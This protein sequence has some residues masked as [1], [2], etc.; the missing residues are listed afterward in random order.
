MKNINL[1]RI[2]I[3][4]WRGKNIDLTFHEGV[5]KIS[6]KNEVGKTT[7]INAWNW[8]FTSYT[9]PTSLKNQELFDNKSELTH[10][11]PVAR[12]TLHISIDGVEHT[13]ERTAQAKFTRPQGSLEYVKSSTDTYTTSIDGF[14]ISAR[15]FMSWIEENIC[16]YELI[17]FLLDGAFF[18]TMAENDRAKARKALDGV[19]GEICNE[20]YMGDYSMITSL[21]GRCTVEQLVANSSAELRK[22]RADLANT[23]SIL[24]ESKKRRRD[25][26]DVDPEAINAELDNVN[27][28][29]VRIQNELSDRGEDKYRLHLLRAKR[30]QVT[31]EYSKLE[32]EY[33]LKQK[34]EIGVE[35]RLAEHD[36]QALIIENESRERK[37]RLAEEEVEALMLEIS[38]H[39]RSLDALVIN[40]KKL[41]DEQSCEIVCPHCK[42][43]L[44]KDISDI[45][46]R[47]REHEIANISE[48]VNLT[49]SEIKR[50]DG[51]VS[52]LKDQIS[53]LRANLDTV[54][55][56]DGE[57]RRET[58]IPFS[59]T[60]QAKNKKREIE[61]IENEISEFEVRDTSSLERSK[62]A[63]I[64]KKDALIVERVHCEE[65]E[66]L[67][68]EIK[69]LSDS[70]KSI[71][72]NVVY[73]E[74]VIAKSKEFV[75][76]RA[77]IISERIN[78]KLEGYRVL[79]YSTQKD[80]TRVPD[81]VVVDEDGVKFATLSNSARIRAN[82]QMQSLFRKALGVCMPTWIDECSIFDDEHLPKPDGQTIY[83][84][85]GNSD[86]LVVE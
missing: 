66:K 15:E 17:P 65:A 52:E 85:A 36:R 48:R 38:E 43:P 5:N 45:I 59:E 80:G 50:K 82:L 55:K 71:G 53:T 63:L 72:A 40:G 79:M 84:F 44:S 34:S 42:L 60:E 29:L 83:L 76:E 22:L 12:V 57:L 6:A 4:E 1:N 25:M 37:I 41:D 74:G 19:V 20:D 30:E 62:E 9:S 21:L 69:R 18:T 78:S 58:Q 2:E 61:A 51:L 56:V 35:S 27:A 31:A 23:T 26:G 67:D 10:E 75:E 70:K 14:A 24:E 13:L 7:L 3:S 11:T 47:R 64:A 49:L 8:V 46:K 77:Q 54:E 68:L 39:N 32:A 86:N 16:P 81:C 33:T 73:M 28:D